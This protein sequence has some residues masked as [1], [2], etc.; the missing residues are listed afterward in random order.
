VTNP[1]PFAALSGVVLTDTLPGDTAF[2][3]AT[4]PYTLSGDV[5]TWNLPALGAGEI[6]TREMAVQV[7]MT[8]TG[9]IANQFY[10]ASADQVDTR[11]G[12]PVLTQIYAL[13]VDKSASAGQVLPGDLLTYTLNVTNLHPQSPTHSVVLSDVLPANT[14]FIS[15]SGTFTLTEDTV[16]WEMPEIGPGETW[17][18]QLVVRVSPTT[19][20]LILNE[21]YAAWS[22][23]VLTPIAGEPVSTMTG[24]HY[25][26]PVVF[27]EP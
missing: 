25:S 19:N 8:F 22:T 13:S 17:S 26:I 23:E 16:L 6:W 2:V 14:E 10:G 12:T 3:S 27:N 7:P 15:A 5:V 18:E 21:H 11:L 4:A 1:H 9:T 20:E 24:Y